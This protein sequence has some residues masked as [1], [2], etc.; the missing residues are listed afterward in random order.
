MEKV[1]KSVLAGLLDEEAELGSDDEDRDNIRKEINKGDVEEN[2]EGMDEDLKDFVV[3][4]RDD[5]IVGEAEEGAYAK[6]LEQVEIDDH[7]RKMEEI[8][9]VIY[10]RNNK[11]RK[12]FE[13]GADTGD[14][15]EK[16]KQERL[17]ER[18][19]EEDINS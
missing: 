14:D 12:H 11:K 17:A 10:G 1:K 3:H 6:Y 15:Y 2:E 7:R 19:K 4:Q 8:N 5:E 13:L 9:A 16:R 18:Q